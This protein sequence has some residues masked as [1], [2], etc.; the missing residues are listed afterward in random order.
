MT[1]ESR[2]PED[3]PR[4][5]E[6]TKLGNAETLIG[7]GAAILVADWLFFDIILDGY[8]FFTGTLLVA[9]YALFTLWVRTNRPSASWPVSYSW[10]VK[11]LG[12]TAGALGLLELIG[13]L[14]YG[15][16]I[17]SDGLLLLLHFQPEHPQGAF[18]PALLSH[19]PAAQGRRAAGF[20]RLPTQ[21]SDPSGEADG[22]ALLRRQDR[23]ERLCNFRFRDGL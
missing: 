21:V 9:A 18:E 12:Y 20:D 3:Q 4:H 19:L 13:D 5:V 11:V 15:Q 17:A 14:R 6:S 8:Y 22:M 23:L 7:I 10:I 16:A 1:N 2:S